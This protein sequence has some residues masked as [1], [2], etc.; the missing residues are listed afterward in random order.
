MKIPE[1]DADILSLFDTLELYGLINDGINKYNHRNIVQGVT[2]DMVGNTNVPTTVHSS[3]G[4]TYT[5]Q[6]ERNDLNEDLHHLCYE[7][8]NNINDDDDKTS[9]DNTTLADNGLKFSNT[10][11]AH[12]VEEKGW[13]LYEWANTYDEWNNYYHTPI[14]ENEPGSSHTFMSDNNLFKLIKIKHNGISKTRLVSKVSTSVNSDFY[15][16][17]RKK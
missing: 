11:D 6:E 12:I 14:E 15:I 1:N 4:A 10:I 5:E 2:N 8:G 16:C 17:K 9:H 13:W 7:L 3:N